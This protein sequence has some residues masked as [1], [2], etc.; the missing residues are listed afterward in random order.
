MYSNTSLPLEKT[1][2]RVRQAGRHSLFLPFRGL[3]RDQTLEGGSAASPLFKPCLLVKL[4]SLPLPSPIPALFQLPSLQYFHPARGREGQNGFESTTFLTV[5]LSR[6]LATRY[7][8]FPFLDRRL[9]APRSPYSQVS[10]KPGL[11]TQVGG[12]VV[13]CCCW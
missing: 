5:L 2:G 9:P 1:K 10:Q 4:C 6:T 8:V 3:P 11:G 7:P 13:P 12:D